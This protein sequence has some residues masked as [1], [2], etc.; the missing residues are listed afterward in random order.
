VTLLKVPAHSGD[1]FNDIADALAKAGCT[2]PEFAF[3]SKFL[4]PYA[5]LPRWNSIILDVPVRRFIGSC[6]QAQYFNQFLLLQRNQQLLSLT[7]TNVINWPLSWAFISFSPPDLASSFVASYQ[8]GFK[9]KCLLNELPTLERLKVRRPDLYN[10]DDWSCCG[11][12]CLET[13][14]HLWMCWARRSVMDVI[15]KDTIAAFRL[16]VES[17]ISTDLSSA[18]VLRLSA[19][20]CWQLMDCPDTFTFLNLAQG[21]VPWDLFLF[22][23]SCSVS[24]SKC[25]EIMFSCLHSLFDRLR[26][27]VWLPRN[28]QVIKKEVLMGINR[29]MKRSRARR[30]APNNL[31][32]PVVNYSLSTHSAPALCDSWQIWVSSACA[33][34]NSWQDF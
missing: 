15:I 19:L 9:L 6:T 2:A 16:A 14:A 8:K 24:N 25:S 31:V 34:G 13:I 10:T 33:Y 7:R 32:L 11:C 27:D 21:L 3:D 4:A 29:K 18:Q 20:T 22:L 26:I 28:E 12:P 23:S 5:V 1:K 30:V 17:E